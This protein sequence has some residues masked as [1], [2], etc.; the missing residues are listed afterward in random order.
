MNRGADF[1][2]AIPANQKRFYA[3]FQGAGVA[4][5]TLCT[6]AQFPLE[7]NLGL[8]A[9]RT[10]IGLFVVTLADCTTQVLDVKA[11][12]TDSAG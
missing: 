10:S 3:A 8:T 1:Y 6:D 12:I 5:M 9:K 7:A 11:T 4:D 2:K